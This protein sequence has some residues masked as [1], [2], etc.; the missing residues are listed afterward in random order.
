MSER[1]LKRPSRAI[2]RF[3]KTN[4]KAQAFSEDLDKYLDWVNKH[5]LPCADDL[6][7]LTIKG[8][9]LIEH[10]LE[11][12]LNRLLDID[13]IP[14]G[15]DYGA[16]GF[17]QK[18]QLLRTVVEQREPKPN[19]DLFLAIARLNETRNQLAHN[20]KNPQEMEKDIQ[21]FI[22]DYH[23]RAGTKPATPVP[24]AAELKTCILN[25]CRFLRDVQLHL[26]RLEIREQTR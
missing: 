25:L 11:V 16:L 14:T 19:A 18:L 9:L 1:Q 15:N 21:Q 4:A 22:A 6:I 17:N 10:L 2:G 24:T 13:H 20:L 5:L 8:H 12:N 3:E 7:L 26:L 23:K